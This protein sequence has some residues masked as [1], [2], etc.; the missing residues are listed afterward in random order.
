MYL[1][2]SL[3]FVPC[4]HQ[5]IKYLISFA[6]VEDDDDSF[7]KRLLLMLSFLLLFRWLDDMENCFFK[8]ANYIDVSTGK[9]DMI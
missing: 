5:K 1:F 2:L 6:K 4:T 3:S 8:A 7:E 9:A